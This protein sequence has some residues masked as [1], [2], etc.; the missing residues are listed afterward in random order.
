MTYATTVVRSA[1]A[2]CAW[3]LIFPFQAQI[4]WDF[5][6]PIDVASSSY[7]NRCPRL[8]LDADGDPVVFMGQTNEG[9]YVT[10]SE[11]GF[12][13]APQL[14]PTDPG[15][16]LSDAEGPDVATWGNTL[17]LAYQIAG[18]WATGA[19]F[20]RSDDGG[21]TWSPS[22]PI[23]PNATEDHFMPIPAFDDD[24][25]PFVGLKLGSGN[26]AQEGVLRSL[27]GGQNWGPAEPA[28]FSAGNGIACECCPSR[29]IFGNGR[30]HTL[31]RRNNN[32]TRDMWLV[33]SEDGVIWDQQ[34][35]LDPTDWQINAC[36]ETG[37]SSAW[38]PDGRL[39]SV[40]MS[41]GNG[42]SRIY[43]NL[44]DPAS[45]DA[46]STLELTFNQF[47]NPNQNQPDIAV[48]PTHTVVAWEQNEGGYEIQ[49]SVA[50]NSDL[51]SGLVDMAVSL[52]ESLSGSNRHPDVAIHGN[53][54]HVIWQNSANGT[55]KYLRGTL[56][57]TSALQ[58]TPSSSSQPRLTRL[59]PDWVLLRD[60]RPG[61][62]YRILDASGATLHEARCTPNGTANLPTRFL[63]TPTLFV[64]TE[65]ASFP[66]LLRLGKTD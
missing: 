47:S 27:D 50:P 3:C 5:A 61:S 36:P 65:G 7:G 17:G 16:F 8:V 12:F 13:N 4:T 53:T 18:Q 24:G 49:L 35:D 29:T 23:A 15:I 22:Y 66:A 45:N 31:Y 60:A 11:N 54:V 38:L 63:S 46:G 48:G 19:M 40:F 28:S 43:L 25:N 34:L 10:T 44:S 32:N 26:N 14:V 56:D 42:N 6:E 1:L 52:S 37:A 30:Y 21:L 59:G 55:V 51:P 20:M 62:T 64:Q 39:I 33:S 2:G 57:G 58:P 41:A 9:L